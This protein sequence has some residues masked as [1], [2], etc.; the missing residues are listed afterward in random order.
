MT[1]LV[2]EDDSVYVEGF[3]DLEVMNNPSTA[4]IRGEWFEVYNQVNVAL[5]G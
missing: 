5:N 3:V 1:S 2:D 4:D